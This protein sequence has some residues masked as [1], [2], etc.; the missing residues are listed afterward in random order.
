[1][2]SHSCSSLVVGSDESEVSTVLVLE[3]SMAGVVDNSPIRSK[4]FVLDNGY[5]FGFHYCL[6]TD[7]CCCV[8][9]HSE[10]ESFHGDFVDLSELHCYDLPTDNLIVVFSRLCASADDYI[11]YH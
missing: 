7:L 4:N 9:S 3:C 10:R 2:L 8:D 11:E 5:G 6:S 1:M